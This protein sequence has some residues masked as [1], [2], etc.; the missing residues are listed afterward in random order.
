[1]RGLD[2]CTDFT[3][4]NVQCLLLLMLHNPTGIC[5]EVSSEGGGVSSC[6]ENSSIRDK[7]RMF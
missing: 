5:Y 1:V 2:F 3:A 7:M 6:E 4:K